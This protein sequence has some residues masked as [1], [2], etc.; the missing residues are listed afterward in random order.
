MIAAEFEKANSRIVGFSVSG[1]SGYAEQGADIVC[2]SVSSAVWMTING[3]EQ[4]MGLSPVYTQAEAH[5]V[6]RLTASDIPRAQV[7]LQSLEQFLCNLST[8]YGNY[9]TVKEVHKHV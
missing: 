8:D 1:H 5:V 9:L 3:L 4:V 7:L 2:A 6:C